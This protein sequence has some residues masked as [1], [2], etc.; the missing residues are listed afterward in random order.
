M[1]IT[2]DQRLLE[3]FTPLGK[4]FLLLDKFR[5]E[6]GLSELF[7]F[8]LDL[9]HEEQWPGDDP[10]IVDATELLGKPMGFTVAQPDGTTRFFSGIVSQF[11]QGNRDQRFTYYRAVIVPQLWLL[12]QRLQSRI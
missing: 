5:G 2:Q 3:V 4:D 8:E 6:E 11:Y 12:T 10:T 9:L 7:R 1:P